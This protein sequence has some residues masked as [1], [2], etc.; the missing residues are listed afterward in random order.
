MG[1]INKT[2]RFPQYLV[3][4]HKKINSTIITDYSYRLVFSILG[5]YL[6]IFLKIVQRYMYV[7]ATLLQFD[8]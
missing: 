8:A 3:Q 5:L 4:H 6:Q 1:T 7:F 2:Q